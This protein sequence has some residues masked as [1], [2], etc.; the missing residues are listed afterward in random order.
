M[1]CEAELCPDEATHLY[2]WRTQT[3]PGPAL[4]Y[5]CLT[6]TAEWLAHGVHAGMVEARVEP[7]LPES[8]QQTPE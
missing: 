8:F 7:L 4:W 5:G 1:K 2:T 3:M 6:H